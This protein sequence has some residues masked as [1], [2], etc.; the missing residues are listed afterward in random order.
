MIHKSVLSPACY[1]WRGW[2]R[3]G[4]SVLQGDMTEINAQTMDL[5][6]RWLLPQPYP[7]C[8]S[9]TLEAAH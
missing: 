6:R 3:T 9:V 8:I 4:F 2:C 1:D 7:S 5:D